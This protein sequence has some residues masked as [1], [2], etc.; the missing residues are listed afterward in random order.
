MAASSQTS[1]A[2]PKTTISSGSSASSSASVFGFVN[3]SKFF[4][5]RRISRPPAMSPGTSP[6]GNGSEREGQR[7]TLLRLEDLLRAARAAEAMRRI[8][9]PEVGRLRDLRIGQLVVVRRGDVDEPGRARSIDEALH[10]GRDVLRVR[11]VELAVRLHEVDLRVDVPED[12]LH[13][14][15]SSRGLTR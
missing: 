4:F 1:V 6:G 2:T 7:V 9:V 11:H 10:R 5:S 15:S 12:A 13:V 3:T 8:R 14:T